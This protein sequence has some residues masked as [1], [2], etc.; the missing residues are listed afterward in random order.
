MATH[1]TSEAK[2]AAGDLGSL[3]A[4]S[5]A[6]ERRA[7]EVLVE[8]HKNLVWSIIRV[9]GIR[10]SDAEDIFQLVFLRLFERQESIRDPSRLPGWLATTTRR[11]CYDLT[12]QRRRVTPSTLVDDLLDGEQTVDFDIRLVRDERQRAVAEAFAALPDRCRDLLRVLAVDPPLGYDEVTAILGIA[13][14]SIGPTRQRCLEK[15]R[16]HSAVRRIQEETS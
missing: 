7:F 11:E 14:G 8:R 15:L 6:G 12:R 4:A 16:A 1:S 2:A 13:R 5:I 9:H 3:L 10:G